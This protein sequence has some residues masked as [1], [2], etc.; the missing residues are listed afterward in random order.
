[1][2]VELVGVDEQDLE[3][4]LLERLRQPADDAVVGPEHLHGKVEAGQA[5]LDRERPR[6]VHAGAERREDADAPVADLVGEQLDHD[7]AIVGYRTRRLR[8]LV[9]VVAEVRGRTGVEAV[10]MQPGFGFRAGQLAQLAG[11]RPEGATEL[12]RTAWTVAFPERGLGGLPRRGRDDDTVE[13]DLL[14][15]PGGG[16]EH[17]A[18]AD[19][20]LVDH[21]LVE[22]ADSGTVGQEHAEQAAVGN[23]A[24]ARDRDTLRAFARPHPVLHPIPDDA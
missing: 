16:P 2:L 20:A 3:R 14:Y 15:P 5:L 9:E 11:Q 1:E 22:L 6:R 10:G 7:R 21:L 18:L 17:E 19:S 4:D 8:L 13:G 24:P 12:E 23:R